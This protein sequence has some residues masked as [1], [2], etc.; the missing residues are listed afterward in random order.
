MKARRG[1]SLT[2]RMIA[3]KLNK[4]KDLIEIGESIFTNSEYLR[5]P[6]PFSYYS[7]K[8]NMETYVDKIFNKVYELDECVN[9]INQVQNELT[10]LCYN[11]QSSEK[12]YEEANSTQ[13]ASQIKKLNLDKR[14][15]SKQSKDVVTKM[16]HYVSKYHKKFIPQNDLT[17]NDLTQNNILENN[18]DLSENIFAEE[19]FDSFGSSEVDENDIII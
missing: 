5:I 17:K 3:K 9:V 18:S 14:K 15:L 10:E 19:D 16:S 2:N 8:M 13:I 11:I 7:K 1:C 4:N 12:P 6:K